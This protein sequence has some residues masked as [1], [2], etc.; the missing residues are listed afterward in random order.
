MFE[1]AW[2]RCRSNLIANLVAGSC[3]WITG[4]IICFFYYKGGYFTVLLD[5]LGRI[6]KEHG[7]WYSAVATSIF[8][9]VI[10]Y[11]CL[12]FQ[13][14]IPQGKKVSWFVFFAVFWAIKGVEVDAFY[15]LQFFI[16][17]GSQSVSV[18]F[19]KVL[20]DLFVY[21]VLWSA[22]VTAIFY[23]WKDA[24]F[25]WANVQEIRNFRKLLSESVFLLLS[26]WIIWIPAVTIIYAMPANLQIPCFNLN[27]CF[28]VLV[29][30]CLIP[31]DG[32]AG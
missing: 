19:F 14:S 24:N 23:G 5:E 31:K 22:P 27:L 17:G 16:F 15:R 9:G 12:L 26:T 30:S 2:G 3:V 1:Q 28:F 4:A 21:C 10:P 8:G 18:I 20:N 7:F 29:I 6:K 13:K 32:M 25:S 11:S